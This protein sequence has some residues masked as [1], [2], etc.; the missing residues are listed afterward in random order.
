MR[1]NME[2]T[3]YLLLNSNQS[4]F[5]AR[6]HTRT[7]TPLGAKRRVDHPNSSSTHQRTLQECSLQTYPPPLGLRTPNGCSP[8]PT[9]KT[10]SYLHRSETQTRTSTDG[11]NSPSL[12]LN[13]HPHTTSTSPHLHTTQASTCTYHPQSPNTFAPTR[14]RTSESSD[15]DFRKPRHS[16]L[17]R[18]EEETREGY[19]VGG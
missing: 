9:L 19:G 6:N 15:N 8:L 14:S 11:Y 18:G 2:R 4:L 16:M 10:A 1:L 7:L 13:A 3:T 12:L 17:R 5:A